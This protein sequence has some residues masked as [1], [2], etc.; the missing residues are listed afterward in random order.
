VTTVLVTGF[1]PF[2]G[3]RVNA[4]WEAVRR[5][6][7]SWAGPERLVVLRLPVSFRRA[8]QELRVAVGD[9]DPTLVVCVG[10]A[11]GRSA[12]GI[13]RVALNVIDA[14]IP[15]ADGSV[16]IDVPVIAGAPAAFFLTLPVKACLT[17]VE[18]VDV[19]VEVSNSA[20]TYVCN[21][22]AYALAHLLTGR[23]ATRGGFV[24]VPRTPEQV[25]D[26]APALE[27]ESSARALLAIV[28]A[29]LDVAIDAPR[30]AGALA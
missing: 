28:R 6:E 8:R 30:Q 3:H 24:H 10:E 1:E 29:S 23:P 26:G 18:K 21:A 11:G 13:E 17:A 27:T 4:S 20:G 7:D 12:V 14:R 2:D 5:F 16:P 25:V 19:P 15:D 9:V 22:T